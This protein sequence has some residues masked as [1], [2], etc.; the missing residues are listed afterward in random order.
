MT[1]E[2]W[3][4]IL[5]AFLYFPTYQFIFKPIMMK[6]FPKY[7]ILLYLGVASFDIQQIGKRLKKLKI[8]NPDLFNEIL[9]KAY[10]DYKFSID[11]EKLEKTK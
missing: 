10:I 1:I 3:Q 7:S 4:A 5:A 9:K 11:G 8:S 6:V 2:L